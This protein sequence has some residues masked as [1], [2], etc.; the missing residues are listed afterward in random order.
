MKNIRKKSIFSHVAKDVEV[1]LFNAQV[2]GIILYHARVSKSLVTYGDIATA[3]RI[4]PRGA[5][6]A[7]AIEAITTA[8]A[9]NGDEIITAIV[10]GKHTGFP[11]SGFFK[12]CR[13][14]GFKIGDTQIDEMAFWEDQ[15]KKLEI[16]Y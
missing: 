16:N 5:Q 2:Y 3:V 9:K 4:A 15:L 6:I 7:Q 1:A 10:V 14:L 11:G 8:V 12:H 13:R